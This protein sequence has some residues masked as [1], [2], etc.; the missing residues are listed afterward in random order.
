MPSCGYEILQTTVPECMVETD[1]DPEILTKLPLTDEYNSV[2]IGVGMG[3]EGRTV[4]ACIEFLKNMPKDKNLVI[5]ADGLNI[6]SQ[7]RELVDDLPK[8]TL[9]TPHPKEL[10]RLIGNW[11]NDFDKLGKAQAFCKIGRAHV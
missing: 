1:N 3:S 6:L 11:E 9:L 5:D 7:N 8:N 4:E 10:M 2:G